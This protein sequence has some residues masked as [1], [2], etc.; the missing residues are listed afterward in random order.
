MY[1]PV[2]QWFSSP[3]LRL[4]HH[5]G[6]LS[7]QPRILS[8]RL[9]SGKLYNR[10]VRSFRRLA[11]CI[12][13]TLTQANWPNHIISYHLEDRKRGYTVKYTARCELALRVPES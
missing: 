12:F 13:T 4:R 6:V 7:G 2:C 3:Q 5:F 9:L 10:W 11:Y 8:I 1:I